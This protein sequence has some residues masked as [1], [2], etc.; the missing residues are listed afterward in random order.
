MEDNAQTQ[1]HDVVVVPVVVV[2][3][4]IHHVLTVCGFA[5]ENQR[6][7]IINNEGFQSVVDFG[8]LDGEKDV[9]EMV[10]QPFGG[11]YRCGRSCVCGNYPGK[12]TSGALLLGS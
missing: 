8:L 6:T 7:H 10:K 3:P 5:N 1:G 2:H 12:E 9:L 4:E 11:S